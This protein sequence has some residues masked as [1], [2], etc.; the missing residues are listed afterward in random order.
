MKK[1]TSQLLKE[2][3]THLGELIQHGKKKIH[4]GI[5]NKTLTKLYFA[6]PP[7]IQFALARYG[8]KAVMSKSKQE[9]DELIRH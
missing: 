7:K 8:I 4:L 2:N 5:I 9:L 6:S 1:Q 3:L